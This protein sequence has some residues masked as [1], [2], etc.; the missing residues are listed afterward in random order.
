MA[1]VMAT[2][3]A[4]AEGSDVPRFGLAMDTLRR[5]QVLNALQGN[6]Y[7]VVVADSSPDH[8]GIGARFRQLGAVVLDLRDNGGIAS[9]NLAGISYA[10][11]HG[12]TAIMR[13]EPE[14]NGWATLDLLEQVVTHIF[15]GEDLVAIGRN[16]SSYMTLPPNQQMSERIMSRLIARLY[17]AGRGCYLPEDTASGIRVM[18]RAGAD[19]VLQFDPVTYG[20]QWEFLWFTLITAIDQ[21]LTVGNALLGY[22][23]PWQMVCEEDGN[24]AFD[25]K[26]AMQADLIVSK[27]IEFALAHGFIINTSPRDWQI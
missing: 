10:L 12:A 6:A 16:P 11:E 7:P 15:E 1:I 22:E 19:H 26:R 27:V 24:P 5:Y 3:Y 4:N 25:A 17:H 18:S 14:K 23:H 2:S 8:A 21:G 20:K 9:Q 13:Q